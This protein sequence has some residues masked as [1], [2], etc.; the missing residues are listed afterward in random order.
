VGQIRLI[1]CSLDGGECSISLS[2]HF[3]TRYLGGLCV[4][5]ASNEDGR[6]ADVDRS[7]T[8]SVSH[9][10]AIVAGIAQSV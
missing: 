1:T 7:P 9:F 2:G 3:T 10:Y 8:Y 5:S 4:P 6:F